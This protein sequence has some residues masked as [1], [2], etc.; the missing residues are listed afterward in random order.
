VLGA[1][2]GAAGGAVVGTFAGYMMSEPPIRYGRVPARDS[3]FAPSFYDTWPPGYATRPAGLG[4]P[5][6]P[7]RPG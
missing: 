5:P 2:F 4:T 7:A 1:E 6:P 3:E